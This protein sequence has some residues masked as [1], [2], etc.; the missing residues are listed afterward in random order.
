MAEDGKITITSTAASAGTAAFSQTSTVQASQG[1]AFAITPASTTAPT[2]VAEE[3]APGDTSQAQASKTP[4]VKP[5]LPPGGTALAFAPDHIYNPLKNPIG[6]ASN[7]VF[8]GLTELNKTAGEWE[9][10]TAAYA[11][12][13]A[14]ALESVDKFFGQASG[15]IGGIENSVN[16]FYGKVL[17]SVR[18]Q[19][20]SYSEHLGGVIAGLDGI[21]KDPLNPKNLS[22][23]ATSIMNSVSPGLA[24][25][26][27]GSMQNLH[28]DKLAKAPALLFSSIQSLVRSIDNL[29]SIPLAF[30][31]AIY[32]G[33]INF[34][35]DIGRALNDLIQGFA[36]FLFDFLDAALGGALKEIMQLLDSIGQLAGQLGGLANAIAG[37]N[38][39][40][41]AALSVT[42]F[43][44][45]INSALTNP[46][47][48]VLLYLPSEISSGYSQIMNNLQNP[49]NLIN[50]LIPD[51]V[52]NLFGSLTQITGYGF[53]GNMGYG[54]AA[55]LEG[56]QGGVISGILDNFAAQYK[57]L[58][59]LLGGT[60]PEPPLSYTPSTD[61]GYIQ[62]KRYSWNP[63]TCVYDLV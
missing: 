33:L 42:N 35:R 3:T 54:F 51:D 60:P 58:G 17:G 52:S 48:T 45:Q 16:K 7:A 57:I 24:D 23:M 10:N 13:F 32:H 63:N 5:P 9:R 30:L 18:K 61:N 29:I 43:T 50:Q 22:N 40:S 21:V 39:V 4:C 46:L 11:K 41:K 34:I 6:A 19:S 59:P 27:N 38:V 44:R 15:A 56:M 2:A 31:S 14:P 53:N 12:T 26:V 8:N 36:D 37:V 55:V 47:D 49:Q 20:E 62:G 25:K 28:L 1:D